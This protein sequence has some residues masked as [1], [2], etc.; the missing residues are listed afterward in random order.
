ERRTKIL[1]A[2]DIAA[3]GIDIS[4]LSHV[5]NY[6]LPEVPETY[7]HRIGRTGRSGHSGVAISFSDHEEKSLLRNGQKLIDKDIPENTENPF[8]LANKPKKKASKKS[9]GRRNKKYSS[10]QKANASNKSEH[11]NGGRRNKNRRGK[12]SNPSK[13]NKSRGNRAY[14]K[15][16]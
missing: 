4:E 14:A 13:K 7:V 15:T 16:R 12:N 2:T 3:R 10:S 5:I 1:V 6:N 9:N 8:P 11:S